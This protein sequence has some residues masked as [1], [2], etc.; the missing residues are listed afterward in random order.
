MTSKERVLTALDHRQA[1][2]VPLD[3]GATNNTCMHRLIERDVKKALG[4]STTEEVTRAYMLGIVMPDDSIMEYF[5]PDCVCVYL[6]EQ[7]P[8]RY[9]EKEDLFYDAWGIGYKRNPDGYYYNIYKHPL[10]AAETVDEILAYECPKPSEY[11]LE[12]WD[13]KAKKY[14]DKCVVLEGLRSPIFSL[15]SWLR[16]EENFYCD[17]VSDDGMIDALL[18]KVEA[19]Y[20]ELLEFVFDRIGDKLDV[21]K[22]ADDL[23]AQNSLLLSPEAYRRH[24][25]PRQAKLYQYAKERTGCKILL[26]SCGSVRPL[27]DDFIE[28][29]VDALNPVQLTA[30]GMQPEG[31]KKDFGDRITFWG[32]GIDTQHTLRFG[33]PE[34]VRKAVKKNMSI[35]KLGG[36]F[37]FTQVHNITPG[38]PIENVLAMYD[39]YYETAA[40]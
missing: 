22:F 23:G 28:I 26:H 29:G 17:L 7:K 24:I 34:D 3:I 2:R 5:K 30:A 19:C 20:M 13:M 14:P 27:I 39:A 12:G 33:S 32:G 36:G 40:Y 18:D 8:W 11:M 1:D 16:A 31:L 10:E 38:T 37:V 25:K 9:S 4:L 15:P 21:V 6:N 35:F